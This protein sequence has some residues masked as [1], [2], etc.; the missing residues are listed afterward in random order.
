MI[1]D[2]AGLL[3]KQLIG[4][5]YISFFSFPDAKPFSG[6]IIRYTP[7]N[8]INNIENFFGMVHLRNAYQ[9]MIEYRENSWPPSIY[10]FSNLNP[11]F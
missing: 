10:S 2:Q 6:R 8:L 5:I 11:I 9:D 3:C 7:G 4:F 1:S